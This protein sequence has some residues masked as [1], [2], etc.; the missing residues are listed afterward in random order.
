[1]DY[2]RQGGRNPVIAMPTGTGKSGVLGMIATTALTQYSG[3]TVMAL[4]HVKELI[5]QDVKA[6]REIWPQAPIGIFSAGLGRA[7]IG[8]PMTFGGIASIHGKEAVFPCP[9]LIL[10]DEA[11]LVSPRQDTMYME[12]IARFKE[13]NPYLRAI[14]LT[15]TA[16]RLGQ[17]MITDEGLF[18]DIVY[19][20][21]GV[22]AFNRLI[23]EGYLA[24]VIPK[25]TTAKIDVSGIGIVNGDYN[26]KQL[27]IATDK[28]EITHEALKELCYYGQDRWS[29]LVFASGV[30]H[31]E[32]VS[33]ALRNQFGINATC[34]HSRM[35]DAIRDERI[36]AFKTGVYRAIVGNNV[37]TTGFDHPPV[38]LIGMLRATCSPGLWVQMLGRGTRPYDYTNP[39]QYR[40]GFNFVKRNCLALDFAG[41]AIRLGP[42]N[43]PRIPHRKGK[44][45][46]EIPV[47]IC[48]A[49]GAY[50]HAAARVCD[51]CG[52]EFHMR[53]KFKTESFNVELIRDE[54]PNIET[55]NVTGVTYQKHDRK[56]P[57]SLKVTYF[58]DFQF[59]T[60]WI[61]LEHS[62]NIRNKACNWWHQRHYSDPP[63]TIDEALLLTYELQQPKSIRVWTNKPGSNFPEVLGYVF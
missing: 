43:D 46:G 34:V 27:Q 59:F 56:H 10:V 53:V 12:T 55:F 41:N 19:D 63:R 42:I 20:I 45:T 31:A 13:R 14:G 16:F 62:G 24:P 39:A 1:M 28:A 37:F 9:D 22:D 60:E 25:R 2:F 49:C 5:E 35:K 18:T 11:H 17:G 51:Y 36:A 61:C 15:A 4:T 21:T 48:D 40:P 26:Q 50:N 3:Q 57:P 58:S 8:A 44:G 23:A 47:R 33:E 7:D 6:L 32:H 54:P 29:W 52:A 30:D 38:D